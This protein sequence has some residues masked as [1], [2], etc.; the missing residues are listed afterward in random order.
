MG[1]Y[2]ETGLLPRSR[3]ADRFFGR[4]CGLDSEWLLSIPP[5]QKKSDERCAY[6]EQFQG[7]PWAGGDLRWS[8][9][10]LGAYHTQKPYK[11]NSPCWQ[12]EILSCWQ[13]SIAVS[14][15]NNCCQQLEEESDLCTFRINY[16]SVINQVFD[17]SEV[18]ANKT[19]VQYLTSPKRTPEFIA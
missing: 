4:K 12:N 17:V 6:T 16:W 7:I 8:Q 15:E 2:C 11:L 9:A 5:P 13:I 14:P 19:I 10:H 1:F 3:K 18:V